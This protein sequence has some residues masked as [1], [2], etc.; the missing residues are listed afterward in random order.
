[1]AELSPRFLSVYALWPVIDRTG[2]GGRFDFHLEFV[3]PTSDAPVSINGQMVQGSPS[4][5]AES[6]D[7]S[8]LTA[9]K[10]Q[11]GLKL[12]PSKAP[13]QIIVV[14]RVERPSAN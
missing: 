7:G 1:M 14:D 9:V 3:A 12:T 5:S 6:R 4:D 2:L 10:E 11:L 8:L 13:V